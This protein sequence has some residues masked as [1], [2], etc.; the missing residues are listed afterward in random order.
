MNLPKNLFTDGYSQPSLSKISITPNKTKLTLSNNGNATHL[1]ADVNYFTNDITLENTKINGILKVFSLDDALVK[2][3]SFPDGF[4][5]NR[6][7]TINFVTTLLDNSIKNA[8]I[9]V[10]FT[11]LNK[12]TQ[13][14]NHIKAE[15]NL[16]K[17]Q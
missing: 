8:K 10:V 7:G 14:S 16:D 17:L 2:T 9:D 15:V 3:S 5:V 12:T 1:K 11:T 6:S 13:L 4:T